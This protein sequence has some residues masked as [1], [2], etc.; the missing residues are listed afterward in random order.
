MW[1]NVTISGF[2][3]QAREALTIVG[4][5]VLSFNPVISQANRL[6]W[7]AYAADHAGLLGDESLVTP[8]PG[9]EWPHNRTVSFGIYSKDTGNEIVY[10]SGH[11]K[12]LVPDGKFTQSK[13]TKLLS[14]STC[15]QYL[16]VVRR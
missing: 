14:C 12:V 13:P 7:E 4:G 6:G 9:A 2:S 10:E 8:D 1:P 11:K 5:R 16:L 3:Q 15:T